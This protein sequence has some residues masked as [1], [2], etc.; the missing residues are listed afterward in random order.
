MAEFGAVLY[1]KDVDRLTAFY[2]RVA[3]LTISET[4]SG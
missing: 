1:V 4:E 3:G 2:A